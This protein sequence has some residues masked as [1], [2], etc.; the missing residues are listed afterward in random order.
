MI[1]KHSYFLREDLNSLPYTT[2]CIKEALRNYA[3]VPFIQRETKE[4]MT[5]DGH[6]IPAGKTT[7][8]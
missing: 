4:A 5:I 3:T 6:V 7:F 2:A 8:L 1:I